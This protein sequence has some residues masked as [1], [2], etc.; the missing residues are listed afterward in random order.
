MFSG[1]IKKE[2]SPD[3]GKNL[4]KVIYKN[5]KPTCT[6]P[7]FIVELE[8]A[9]DRCFFHLKWRRNFDQVFDV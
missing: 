6:F 7:I 8:Q 3:I 1:G 9:L 5:I 4:F 2:H